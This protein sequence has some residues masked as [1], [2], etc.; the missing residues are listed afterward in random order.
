M[1]NLITSETILYYV[2]TCPP[3]LASQYD[4]FTCVMVFLVFPTL[5]HLQLAV[6][7]PAFMSFKYLFYALE[8]IVD[9]Y[10]FSLSCD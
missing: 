10:L 5:F 4:V 3:F 8:S 1:D 6:R 2:C 9:L 7:F